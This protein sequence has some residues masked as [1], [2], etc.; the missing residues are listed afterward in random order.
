MHIYPLATGQRQKLT[1]GRSVHFSLQRLLCAWRNS[2]LLRC[3]Q[4]SNVAVDFFEYLPAEFAA[5][6]KPPSKDGHRKIVLP[7]DAIMWPGCWLN[8]DHAIRVVVKTTPLSSQPCCHA[9]DKVF[10]LHSIIVRVCSS[11]FIV[12]RSTPTVCLSVKQ[13]KYRIALPKI[14]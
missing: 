5:F 14:Q 13:N 8:Q 2:L 10:F 6:S 9:A 7:K 11:L 3:F 1:A 12:M 4:Q